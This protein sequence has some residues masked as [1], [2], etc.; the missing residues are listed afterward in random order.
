MQI[1]RSH[2]VINNA[3][4]ALHRHVQ[5]TR[6]QTHTNYTSH[7]HACC[8]HKAM[9]NM[10]L[11]ALK[12]GAITANCGLSP[13]PCRL[14]QQHPVPHFLLL[15]LPLSHLP[16]SLSLH[17]RAFCSRQRHLYLMTFQRRVRV[18]RDVFLRLFWLHAYCIKT[19]AAPKPMTPLPAAAAA[20]A[21]TAA[22]PTS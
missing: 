18:R 20:A 11:A 22:T 6:I 21:S 9:L 7:T 17:L 2:F 3:K 5:H 15:L 1:N 14:Q 12:R 4:R 13:G 16:L 19:Q 8:C 10:Q